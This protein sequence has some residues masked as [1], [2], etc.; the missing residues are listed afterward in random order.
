MCALRLAKAT[1]TE[2]PA[3]AAALREL[4]QAKQLREDEVGGHAGRA[5]VWLQCEMLCLRMV[6]C[7]LVVLNLCSLYLPTACC[8]VVCSCWSL[9][10]CCALP[11]SCA[12]WTR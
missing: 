3:M 5:T 6:T 4:W 10:S 11:S 7:S 12:L 9:K 1:R 2:L 8:C